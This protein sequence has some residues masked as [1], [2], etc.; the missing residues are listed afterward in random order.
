MNVATVLAELLELQMTEEALAAR[1]KDLRAELEA[2]A[3]H[4][5]KADGAAPSWRAPG[6]GTASLCG[7]DSTELVV[8]D[9][10]AYGAWAAD[11]RPESTDLV[12]RVPVNRMTEGLRADLASL[13]LIG[14]RVTLE[15]HGGVLKALGASSMVDDE[16]RVFTENGQVEGVLSRKKAPYLSLRPLPEAKARAAAR[17]AIERS[18]AAAESTPPS[19]TVTT[20]GAP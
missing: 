12:V 10:A 1:R 3:L 13:D 7:V 15:P 16:G 5:L 11:E 9:P 19:V 14:G 18:D 8:T 17:L 2:E 6:L 20:G 4:R